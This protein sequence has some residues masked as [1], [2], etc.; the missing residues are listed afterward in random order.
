[1]ADVAWE[2]ARLI[3]VSGINGADEQERRGSSAL[4]A[5]LESVK[6]FSRAILGPL[7]APAGRVS[8]FIEVPFQLGDRQVRPD[9]VIQVVYGKKTWTALV[10]VKTG[11]NNLQPGQLECYLDVAHDLGFDVVLTISNEISSAPGEHPT[12]VDKKKLKK[13]A[14]RHLSWSEIHTE[15]VI[16]RVNR[17]VADPD[18]AWI[19]SELIRYLEHPRSG[20]VDFDDMGSS[21]VAV[22]D[23]ATNK[24]L[25]P[26]NKGASEVAARYSQLVAFAGMRLS[27]KLGVEVRSALSRAEVQD[28]PRRVQHAA[29]K[30]V[31]DGVLHGALRVPNAVAPIDVNVD[32]RSGRAVCSVAV[33]APA[34][35]KASTRVNWILRQLA[36]APGSLLIEAVPA[37]AHSGPCFSLAEV[38]D[39]PQLLIGDPKKEIRTFIVRLSAP[40]GTKRGQGRGSF[41]GSVLDLVDRFYVEVVQFLK[42]WTPPAPSVRSVSAAI[43]SAQPEDSIAGALPVHPG[44]TERHERDIDLK[45]DEPLDEPA[46]GHHAALMVAAETEKTNWRF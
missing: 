27:R 39:K 23:G 35:G 40:A 22:R 43:E 11:R 33:Q 6:E 8:A 9:G 15:A 36:Q 1:M 14:L 16:E 41:V 34:Q 13:T 42:V 32:L 31:D 12:P 44:A 29:S 19:L 30:L 24:T 20:A 38:R 28:G 25:R 10:E 37:W 3:P 4:L 26:G 5:V 45:L 18:Q 21:W 46:T 7:G 2:P 17:S